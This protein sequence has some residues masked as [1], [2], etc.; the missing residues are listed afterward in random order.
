MTEALLNAVF[1]ELSNCWMLE[2]TE[3]QRPITVSPKTSGIIRVGLAVLLWPTAAIIL[4][5]AYCI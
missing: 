5:T 3:K 4:R 1:E 2:K